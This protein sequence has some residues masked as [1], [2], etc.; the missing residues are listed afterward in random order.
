MC[1]GC[2]FNK[3]AYILTKRAFSS[4]LNKCGSPC[5]ASVQCRSAS[6][7]GYSRASNDQA[8]KAATSVHERVESYSGNLALATQRDRAGIYS[9]IQMQTAPFQWRGAVSNI[10][11]KC[12]GSEER[13]WLSARERSSR[14]SPTERAGERFLQFY[15]RCSRLVFTEYFRQVLQAGRSVLCLPGAVGEWLMHVLLHCYV[16]AAVSH[17]K[18]LLCMTLLLIWLFCPVLSADSCICV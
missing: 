5:P 16:C 6:H 9:S 12:P 13:D 1:V 11:S 10:A 17:S 8:A 15:M 4:S 18:L 3:D 2:S 7:T 14:A